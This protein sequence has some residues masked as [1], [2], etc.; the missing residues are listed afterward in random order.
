[1]TILT[2]GY[3]SGII[4]AAIYLAQFVVPNAIVLILIGIVQDT[5]TAS[6]WS[7]VQRS[8]A[9]SLWPTVLRTDGSRSKS[10]HKG[11]RAIGWL[12]IFTAILLAVAAVTTPLGLTDTV[13]PSRKIRSV[14]F[15]YVKDLGPMGYGTPP[16]NDQGFGRMC[17]AYY[18]I[19]CPGTHTDLEYQQNAT[20]V[21]ITIPNDDY[22][23]KI[24]REL[25]K[26]YTSGLKQQSQTVS[27]YFDIQSRQYT[28]TRGKVV[29]HNQP[30]V[31]DMYRNLRSIV[32]DNAVEVVEGESTH[33]PP[34]R[35]PNDC[36]AVFTWRRS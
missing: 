26:L 1:M 35:V 23:L 21:N 3:V 12:Q 15:N 25:A 11:V 10:L 6:T 32:L 13:A 8:L 27:S 30:Y 28:Y 22:T 24:P 2:V 17:G 18:P 14:P 34:C 33:G 5:H 16:V 19:P 31:V 7:D 4:A 29:D 36:S 9:S 20:Q